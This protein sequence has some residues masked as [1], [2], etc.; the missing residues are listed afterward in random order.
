MKKLTFNRITYL[1]KLQSLKNTLLCLPGC[2]V[3]NNLGRKKLQILNNHDKWQPKLFKNAMKCDGI[4]FWNQKD[5]NKKLI[6]K[7]VWFKI[8]LLTHPASHH[9]A[10]GVQP[11]CYRGRGHRGPAV[12]ERSWKQAAL[13]QTKLHHYLIFYL[14]VPWQSY[15]STSITNCDLGHYDC[16]FD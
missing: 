10:H 9:A 1:S 6:K 11:R 13:Y 5:N 16:Q 2:R 15:H 14:L 3:G 4:V 12:N 7:I 8:D